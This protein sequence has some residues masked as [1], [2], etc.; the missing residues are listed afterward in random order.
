MSAWSVAMCLLTPEGPGAPDP[1]GSE[2]GV[3]W[4]L[5]MS[6]PTARPEPPLERAST[7]R[8]CVFN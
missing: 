4:L 7:E 6:E 5:C 1:E 2:S 3:V 8:R